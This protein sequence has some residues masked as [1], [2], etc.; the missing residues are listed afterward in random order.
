MLIDKVKPYG[1]VEQLQALAASRQRREEALR[2]ISICLRESKLAQMEGN[3]EL[4]ENIQK[5]IIQ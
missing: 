1:S 3:T 2:E 5:H 4:A